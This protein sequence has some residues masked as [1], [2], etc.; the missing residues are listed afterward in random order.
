MRL[1]DDTML[2]EKDVA[3]DSHPRRRS[4]AV[5]LTWPEI[6]NAEY[7]VVQRIRRAA[8]N[9]GTTLFVINNDGYKIWSTLQGPHKGA[10]RITA[11]ECEFVISLHFESP[12]LYDIFS[13]YALWNPPEF[14]TG[15]GYDRTI[16][17]MASHCDLLSCH[18]D[19]A[20][21]H[22]ENVF[23]GLDRELTIPL[24]TLFHTAPGP[25]PTTAV[26]ET[27]K[28]FYIGINWERITGEKGRHHELLTLLDKENLIQI[29]G[30]EVF[31]G[32]RPWAGYASY[33]GELPFDGSS[34][35]KHI[36]AAGI[37][38]TLSSEAH[39]RSGIMSNRLFEGL[40]AGAVI[41]A[42]RHPFIEKYFSDC[43]YTVD[44]TVEPIALAMAVRDL[45]LHIRG[46]VAEA[47]ERAFRG[48]QRFLEKFSL[49]KCLND[50]L[51]GHVARVDEH[52]RN[53]VGLQIHETTVIL[54]YAGLESDVL[55]AMVDNVVRQT[56]VRV[57]LSIICDSRL[58]GSSEASIRTM[59]EAHKVVL[60]FFDD[61]F[62]VIEGNLTGTPRRLSGTGLKTA[63]ALDAVDTETFCFMQADDYWFQDHLA[64]LCFR[65][66]KDETSTF[67]CS[68]RIAEWKED[69]KP[70]ARHVEELTLTNLWS[71]S[72]G[73]F[74][75]DVGRFLYKS[76]LLKKKPHALIRIL[77]G[78]LHRWF[79]TRALLDGNL[80][81]TNVASYVHLRW[82]ESSLP[83]P[84]YGDAEQF[85]FVRD[86]FRGDM[87]WV[88][89][90]ATLQQHNT[91][92]TPLSTQATPALLEIK[93]GHLYNLAIDGDGLPLLREGFSHPER[94]F[95]WLDGIMGTLTFT[96]ASD[97]RPL[98]LVLTA[99]GRSDSAASPPRCAILIGDVE[100][101][102]FEVPEEMTEFR[103]PCEI[104]TAKTARTV[105]LSLD[106]AEAVST[107]NGTVLDPRKLG[108]RIG[109]FGV[110]PIDAAA[111]PEEARD[112]RLRSEVNI[113]RGLG[114]L[115][116][117]ARSIVV[118]LAR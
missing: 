29:Y 62:S 68:G 34:V 26:D 82:R 93:P 2:Q 41:I 73:F 12:R 77:D 25:Y 107:S 117:R 104:G 37:C 1:L 108:M 45:V 57:H 72:D 38:L 58:R 7:E 17:Q 52:A 54:E 59:I 74:R 69:G 4:F 39:Q 67:C 111:T 102:S 79:N 76:S 95:I 63:E 61:F 94:E 78:F 114:R 101:A 46:N 14:Y 30:P 100:L 49:E 22:A 13:Y 96:V 28:L 48:Q 21:L 90:S 32:I 66:A 106:R 42:N 36:N 24:P 64:S 35:V 40:A 87:K 55:K 115:K 11:E 33:V 105:R 3:N 88:R 116:R 83:A 8:E 18:S 109:K 19:I 9:L 98:E 91:T 65:L 60:T 113:T 51:V 84:F 118:R 71:L 10:E 81:Q 103:F 15:P 5:V 6:K 75:R 16:Q 53:L 50:L 97:D 85:S 43:V 80:S 99:G 112:A 47:K 31:L 70:S 89:L 110:M 23:S 27:S 44:D 20:G 56:N 92:M 86:S